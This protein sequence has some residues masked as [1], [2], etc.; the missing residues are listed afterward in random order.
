MAKRVRHATA[1]DLDEAPSFTKTRLASQLKRAQEARA[2]DEKLMSKLLGQLGV[3]R[4]ELE[5]RAN[6]DFA[7]AR[8]ESAELVK[9]LRALQAARIKQRGPLRARI[10]AVLGQ[11]G[12]T[13]VPK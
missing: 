4:K 3:T 7:R 10:E 8:S 13:E 1:P 12:R 11:I 5:K 2:Y 9:Q 6:D